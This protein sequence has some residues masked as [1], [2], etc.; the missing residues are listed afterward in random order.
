MKPA[1]NMPVTLE[2]TRGGGNVVDAPTWRDRTEGVES[3]GNVVE[4]PTWQVRVESIGEDDD[5]VEGNV[6]EAPTW[7]SNMVEA[8]TRNSIQMSIM[9]NNPDLERGQGFSWD[10][11]VQCEVCLEGGNQHTCDANASM[12]VDT[13]V[14]EEE[15]VMLIL[16]GEATEHVDREMDEQ[17]D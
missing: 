17:S 14:D 7:Q 12:N 2:Q 3:G 10:R 13:S 6:V 4:A 1:N 9:D 15:I 16:N 11:V 8:C 5:W